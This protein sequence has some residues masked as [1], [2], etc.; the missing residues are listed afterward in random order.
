MFVFC[1]VVVCFIGIYGGV[2]DKI[3][4]NC[5]DSVFC[6]LMMGVCFDGCYLGYMLD[7]CDICMLIIILI[8]IYIYNMRNIWLKNFDNY[9]S[10]LC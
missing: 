9:V 6:Y 1:I 7:C 8:K 2:C 10:L 3:C 4:G 5:V